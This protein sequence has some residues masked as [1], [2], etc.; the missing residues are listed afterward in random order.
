MTA[1]ALGAHVATYGPDQ[2]GPFLMNVVIALFP[3]VFVVFAPLLFLVAMARIPPDRLFAGLPFYVYAV[4]AAVLLYVMVDFL[5]MTKYLPCQPEQDG[6]NFYC[7]DH[8][9]LIPISADAY[10]QGL[11][12][13]ARLF[14]GHEFVF[15]GLA[16]LLGYQVEAIRRGRVSLDAAPR[17][18][19][20]ERSPLPYPLS[21]VIGLQ[22]AIPAE[23]CAAR[24][25]MPRPTR[26]WSFLGAA[27]GLRGRASE[28]EFRVE[29]AGPQSQLVYAVGRLGRTGEG[30]SIRLLLTFKRWPLM[31]LGATILLAPIVIAFL[32]A[33]GIPLAWYWL[34]ILVAFSIGGNFLFGLDQRRRLLGEIKRL[35][36]ATE[37]PP[38]DPRIALLS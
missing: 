22:T 9:Y 31:V 5:L 12:Y 14:S 24:L 11:M 34:G 26:V 4:G 3:L 33:S 1:A 2:L 20:I 29:M 6:P 32:T 16:A 27:Y 19:V 28:T 21:K 18:D 8:G 15:F 30:T 17:D 38:D 7:N 10:R 37:I 36:E 23:M 25:L 13:A 35:T